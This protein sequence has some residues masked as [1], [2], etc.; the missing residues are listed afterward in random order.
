MLS[1]SVDGLKFDITSNL[2]ELAVL[3]KKKWKRI[4]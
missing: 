3:S 2:G 1:D 4:D